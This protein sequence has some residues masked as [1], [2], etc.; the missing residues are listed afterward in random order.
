MNALESAHGRPLRG[1]KLVVTF[2]H[3]APLDQHGAAPR[4][5]RPVTDA[6]RPTALSMLK[7]GRGREGCVFPFFCLGHSLM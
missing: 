1:R 5:R 6:G 4:A 7:T 2:A 3:Q